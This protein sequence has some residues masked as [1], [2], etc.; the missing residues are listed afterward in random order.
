M[1]DMVFLVFIGFLCP[2]PASKVF[3]G[4]QKSSPKDFLLVVVVYTFFFSVL[5]SAK[6][7]RL[8]KRLPRMFSLIKNES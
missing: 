3:L 7:G 6:D 4:G 2:P 1:V 5:E 8:R